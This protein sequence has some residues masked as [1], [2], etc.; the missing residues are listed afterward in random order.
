MDGLCPRTA[1]V[2]IPTARKNKHA[3]T[4]LIWTRGFR[5]VFRVDMCVGGEEERGIGL[6]GGGLIYHC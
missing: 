6:S 1:N 3:E 5:E 2:S 4:G